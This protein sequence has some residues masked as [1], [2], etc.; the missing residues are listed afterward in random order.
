MS[1]CGALGVAFVEIVCSE[2]VIGTTI[3][4]DVVRD[5]ENAVTDRNDR[6]FVAALAFD[7]TV[8]G[9]ERGPVAAGGRQAGLDQGASQVAVALTRLPTAPFAGTLV[10]AGTHGAP[11]TQVGGRGKPAHVAA[12]FRHDADRADAIDPRNRVQS[13]Q[14]R[15]EWA[16]APIDFRRHATDRLVEE[17]DL[18]QD[19]LDEK[20]VVRPKPA[21]QGAPEVSQFLAQPSSRQVGQD[22]RV[23]GPVHERTEHRPSTDA[24]HIG[25]HGCQLQA[26]VF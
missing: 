19:P 13:G 4:H 5:F 12:G 18:R 22:H 21:L 23:G 2:F 3:A 10:L 6:L 1:S 11:A 24:H 20:R 15:F 17:V 25:D 7:A 26:G 9:L 14:H 16:Q 8:P